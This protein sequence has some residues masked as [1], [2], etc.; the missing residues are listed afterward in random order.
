MSKDNPP[1]KNGARIIMRHFNRLPEQG[2]QPL[3]NQIQSGRCALLIW[4]VQNLCGWRPGRDQGLCRS[5]WGN[6]RS[7]V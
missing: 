5:M 7:I 3:T 2:N 6:T 4:S 1:K